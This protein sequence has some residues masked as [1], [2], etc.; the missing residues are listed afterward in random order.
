[1][2]SETGR[3]RFASFS[4][5]F[6]PVSGRSGPRK[7]AGEA[8]SA[9]S[10]GFSLALEGRKKG[11]H[12]PV[13]WGPC[14]RAAAMRKPALVSVAIGGMVGLGCYLAGPVLAATISGF[15]SAVLAWVGWALRHV[16]QI[17]GLGAPEPDVIA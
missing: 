5:I 9:P 8:V 10:V 2:A 4:A 14:G 6:V 3:F 17:L 7:V 16:W 15:S 11:G 1:V 12:V 13:E